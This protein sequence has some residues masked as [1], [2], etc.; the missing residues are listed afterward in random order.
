VFKAELAPTSVVF[1]K[2]TLLGQQFAK[3]LSAGGGKDSAAV[4]DTPFS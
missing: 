3:Q 4:P 1:V 2:A